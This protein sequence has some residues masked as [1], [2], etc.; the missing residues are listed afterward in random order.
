M[1]KSQKTADGQRLTADGD[2]IYL[3]YFLEKFS[4]SQKN[5]ENRYFIGVPK[6][7]REVCIQSLGIY[8]Y[9]FPESTSVN[10]FLLLG[11]SVDVAIFGGD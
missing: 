1:W 9:F 11:K 5:S 2:V 7:T 8:M 6:H 3:N 4:K 10:Q